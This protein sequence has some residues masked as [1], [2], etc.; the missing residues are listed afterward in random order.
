MH[1]DTPKRGSSAVALDHGSPGCRAGPCHSPDQKGPS[2][3]PAA[4]SAASSTCSSPR[5]KTSGRGREEK[6]NRTFGAGVDPPAGTQ[7]VP[8]VL[9]SLTG[10]WEHQHGAKGTGFAA[11]PVPNPSPHR[12]AVNIPAGPRVPSWRRRGPW[13][14]EINMPRGIRSLTSPPSAPALGLAHGGE[15]LVWGC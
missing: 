4:R 1:E 7:R 2:W 13:H 5:N 6:K 11:H 15:G 3:P 9:V 8:P 12:P 14:P 10:C